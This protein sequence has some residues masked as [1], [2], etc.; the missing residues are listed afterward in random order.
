[1]LASMEIGG[2]GVFLAGFSRSS[3]SRARQSH[4]ATGERSPPVPS[5]PPD[6]LPETQSFRLSAQAYHV[7]RTPSLR[8]V[9]Q[10][11]GVSAILWPL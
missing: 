5:A 1:M 8:S 4:R 11:A 9:R 2:P 6:L 10:A 7:A 3:P